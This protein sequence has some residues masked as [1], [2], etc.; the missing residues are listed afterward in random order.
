MTFPADK[1]EFPTWENK[2]L[3]LG[4][5]GTKIDANILN[6]VYRL[7]ER[8]EDSLGYNFIEGYFDLKAKLQYIL[9]QIALAGDFKADG[10]VPM[11]GNLQLAGYSILNQAK[12][13]GNLPSLDL[14]NAV[15][16][17]KGRFY[18]DV[19]VEVQSW[20][21]TLELRASDV[22]Y[23]SSILVVSVGYNLFKVHKKSEFQEPIKIK[24]YEQATEPVLDE[25]GFSCYW[26]N[27]ADANRIYLV[28]R[29]GSGDQVKTELT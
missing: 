3:T 14:T 5:L 9:D 1:E 24:M 16:I 19:N 6:N 10:S 15:Y 23:A 8:V 28:F 7:L 21:Q 20:T 4:K 2:D 27:T 22:G 17:N 25:D 13:S 18:F 12:I 11:A 29:R 26:K